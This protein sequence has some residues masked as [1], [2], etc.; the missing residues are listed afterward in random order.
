MM[1]ATGNSYGPIVLFWLVYTEFF[2]GIG[3]NRTLILGL[4]IMVSPVRIRVSPLLEV[5]QI[6][7]KHKRRLLS[8]YILDDSLTTTR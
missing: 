3:R 1:D 2:Y 4:K 7:R 8:D 6:S 5:L